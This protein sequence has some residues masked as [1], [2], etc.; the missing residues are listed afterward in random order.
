VRQA[1]NDDEVYLVTVSAG[2]SLDN[3]TPVL[4]RYHNDGNVCIRLVTWYS[5][6]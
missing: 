5:R 3:T 4:M 6:E 2:K 1:T